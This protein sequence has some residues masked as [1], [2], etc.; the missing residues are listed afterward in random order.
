MATRRKSSQL[1]MANN[2]LGLPP[3]RAAAI[4]HQHSHPATAVLAPQVRRRSYVGTAE[5]QD[6][7]STYARNCQR[8]RTSDVLRDRIKAGGGSLGAAARVLS[9][10]MIGMDAEEEYAITN[11][12]VQD[13]SA[14]GSASPHHDP[15]IGIDDLFPV[16]YN[17]FEHILSECQRGKEAQDFHQPGRD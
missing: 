10:V 16:H 1:T 9:A 15:D 11:A 6:T 8:E 14:Q 2:T 5:R 17:N 4:P 13:N 3:H 7:P 12:A